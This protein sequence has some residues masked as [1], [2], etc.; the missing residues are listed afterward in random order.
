MTTTSVMVSSSTELIAHVRMLYKLAIE[1]AASGKVSVRGTNCYTHYASPAYIGAVA[2]VEAY[3]NEI[4]FGPMTRGMMK[5]SPLW[6]LDDDWAEHIEVRQKLLLVPILL[7]GRTFDKSGQ[8]YQDFEMLVRMR[9]DF[10]HYKLRPSRPK[11]VKVLDQRSI[12]LPAHPKGPDSPW[13][14]KISTSEGIRW[15]NNTACDIVHKLTEFIPE[16]HR[17]AIGTLAEGFARIETPLPIVF[18]S[19]E[20]K[21]GPGPKGKESGSVGD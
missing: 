10:V 20:S 11:Y 18:E 1:D 17:D 3:L 14:W 7:F 19:L 16:E 21:K 12:A 9:N 15:A 5:E 4:A 2:A 8:P 13:V 6:Q